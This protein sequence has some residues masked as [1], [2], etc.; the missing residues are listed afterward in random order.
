MTPDVTTLPISPQTFWII[1]GL[2]GVSALSA[3]VYWALRSMDGKHRPPLWEDLPKR[4]QGIAVFL[5]L[6]W[7]GLFALTIIATYVGVWMAIHPQGEASQPNLGLGALLAA[8]LGAPFVIWGTWLKYQTVRFQKEG[9]MTDRINKA[10][11][12]LGAEKTVKKH[13]VNSADK[14][15]YEK[16][17]SGN[18]DYARPVIVEET[19]PNIEV[20]IGAIL[21]LE[22]IAQDSTAHDKGRDHVR[23]ME[24]LCA[25]V[26]ENAPASSAKV[27]LRD[28]YEEMKAGGDGVQGLTDQE[29]AK[30]EGLDFIEEALDDEHLVFWARS[31]PQPREDVQLVMH[32]IGRRT[33]E[34][35][36]VEAAWPDA[37]NE[38]TVWPF[39]LPCPHLPNGPEKARDVVPSDA[40]VKEYRRRLK[41]WS[42]RIMLYKG[43]KLDLQ[44][45]NLQGARLSSQRPDRSD[46]VFS[47][48]ILTGVR[49]D[50]SE[51]SG[52]RLEGAVL[53]QVRVLGATFDRAQLEGA[54]FLDARID[55]L[56][57]S[58]AQLDGVFLTRTQ[59]KVAGLTE[60]QERRLRQTSG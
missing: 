45:T 42:D 60:A 23:V 31:L 52:V 34:Q 15:V 27:S 56:N 40:D 4:G 53:Q 49:M 50:G 17:G 36:R 16:D 57:L 11:E 30:Q 13:L 37:P 25:Y 26:R 33:P 41:L 39:D 28:R 8:L 18:L 46:A 10:V 7:V 21:S 32:V 6:A 29:I 43:Y 12:Q 44:R 38:A 59:R 51:C 19:L 20:R 58:E 9:H 3:L 35:R 1:A 2:A 47:G 24:I 55:G 22:R 5:G 48:A 14:K 54:N